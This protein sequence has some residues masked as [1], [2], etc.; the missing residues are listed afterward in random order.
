MTAKNQ[1]EDEKEG[2]KVGADDYITKPFDMSVVLCRIEAV[3][4]RALNNKQD[5]GIRQ[6]GK[7][8]FDISK[9]LLILG[10]QETSL[11]TKEA[12]LLT[13]LSNKTN[14]LLQRNV[15]LKTIWDND[16]YFSARSMDVYITKLRKVLKADPDVEIKNIHG[17]GYKL[18]DKP[19]DKDA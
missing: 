15:A 3:L 16:D 19:S 8:K 18:I 6:I 1:L 14:S 9:Q 10:D 13:L 11:T 5:N 4:R 7:F 2:F 12:E 17:K